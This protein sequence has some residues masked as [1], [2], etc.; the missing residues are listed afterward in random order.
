MKRMSRLS[1][2]EN[3]DVMF[4]LLTVV[5]GWEMVSDIGGMGALC[6]NC[7]VG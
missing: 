3:K 5:C 7:D 6:R 2:L 1:F 4:G